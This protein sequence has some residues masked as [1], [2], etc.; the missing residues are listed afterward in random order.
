MKI[1]VDA[2]GLWP[3]GGARNATLG[4]LKALAECDPSV[5]YV[6]F[7]TEYEDEL[8]TFPNLH[9]R[10]VSGLGTRLRLRLWAQICL[11]ILFRREQV[12]LVHFMKNMSVFGAPHP[13]VTTVLDM[14]RF[15]VPSGFSKLDI[16]LW[17]RVQP[18]LLQ[19]MDR[20]VAISENTKQDL[21]RFYGLPSDRIEV[22][23]PSFSSRFH[24]HNILPEKL[25]HVLRKY[26][27]R[28]PY[29]LSVGGLA[30]HKNV[31]TALRAFLSLI[32]KGHLADYT[33]VI[34]GEQSHTHVDERLLGLASQHGE[35]RVRLTG[36]VNEDDLL[37]IYAGASL[38]LYPSLYEGFGIAP[39]EAMS[40]GVPVLA[41]TAGPLP[42]VL[43]GSAR[44][45]DLVTDVD[46]VAEGM[47]EILSD[48]HI[49][50]ELRE[51]GL[52][53]ARRFSW[54]RTAQQ[55]LDLYWQLARD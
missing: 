42:E 10:V 20:I 30:V 49:W 19:G 35:F 15:R 34:V 51:R 33:F 3:T 13:R 16:F 43:A 50:G 8:G 32:G 31:Y 23:Y 48:P 45:I 52:E 36:A 46:A 37:Y 39:L 24:E 12:H 7:V 38:F 22:I 14:N 5:E 53:N 55:T 17:H 9:Q 54:T 2:L 41:S 1:G 25:P 26:G 27:I 40:C 28:S 29:M 18:Y 21:V 47:L 6:V 4:W 44:M 11:P